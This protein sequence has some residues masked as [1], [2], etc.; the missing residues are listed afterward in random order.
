[1][2]FSPEIVVFF[3]RLQFCSF[4]LKHYQYSQT[5]IIGYTNSSP[6]SPPQHLDAYFSGLLLQSMSNFGTLVTPDFYDY[7]YIVGVDEIS[8]SPLGDSING[9]LVSKPVIELINW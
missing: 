2:G 3:Y 9:E 5:H 6:I 8:R 7:R 4:L 1:M